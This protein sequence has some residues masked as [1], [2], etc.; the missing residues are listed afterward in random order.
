MSNKQ[1]VMHDT[2]VIHTQCKEWYGDDL[3]SEGRYKMKG[4]RDFLITLT[5]TQAMYNQLEVREAFN[6]MYDQEGMQ[7]R[8][9][10]ISM[11]LYFEPLQV[12]DI[13]CMQNLISKH[14]NDN[15]KEA[16]DVESL[17]LSA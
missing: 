6:E 4:G 12:K 15:L 3:T 2:M 13:A 1:L 14:I 11:E 9:E 10:F 8:Y 7:T 16:F 17:A 5:T